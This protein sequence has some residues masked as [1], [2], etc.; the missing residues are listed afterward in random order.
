MNG[1]KYRTLVPSTA[2]PQG[3]RLEVLCKDYEPEY[4]DWNTGTQLR[5]G[6]TVDDILRIELGDLVW[7]GT[8][9]FRLEN[10]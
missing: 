4:W 2:H 7:Q 6:L 5:F 10:I 9:I 8:T 1:G 3:R